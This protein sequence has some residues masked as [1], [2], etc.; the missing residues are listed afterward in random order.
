MDAIVKKQNGDLSFAR[1]TMHLM[2]I[3]FRPFQSNML[4]TDSPGL[5][6]RENH[7]AFT[8]IDK[9]QFQSADMSSIRI[10]GV[11]YVDELKCNPFLFRIKC[12]RL[13]ARLIAGAAIMCNAQTRAVHVVYACHHR[14]TVIQ[15][16]FYNG[17]AIS[18]QVI[19]SVHLA[20]PCNSS[21]PLDGTLPASGKVF[22]KFESVLHP[23]G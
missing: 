23:G 5:R 19:G 2:L 20:L 21:G 4:P 18:G 15:Q 22:D 12:I 9:L 1:S 16:V 14:C 13:K 3:Q 7:M 11:G 8:G 6:E 17:G 10:R